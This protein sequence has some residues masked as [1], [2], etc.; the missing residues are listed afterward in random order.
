MESF[1]KA[2]LYKNKT[3]QNKTKQTKKKAKKHVNYVCKNVKY[4]VLV[5]IYA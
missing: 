4:N 2:E 3:K 5:K 1:L